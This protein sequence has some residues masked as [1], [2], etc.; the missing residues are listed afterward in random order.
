MN[1]FY[2]YGVVWYG[3]RS[4]P[5]SFMYGELFLLLFIVVNATVFTT[6]SSAKLIFKYFSTREAIFLSRLTFAS[7]SLRG[8]STIQR[9]MTMIVCSIWK[10]LSPLVFV[11]LHLAAHQHQRNAKDTFIKSV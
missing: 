3:T 1:H 8:F 7:K 10:P 2:S 4:I 5:H 9:S 6:V 11:A